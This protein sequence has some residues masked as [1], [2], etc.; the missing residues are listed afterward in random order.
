MNGMPLENTYSK[1]ISQL[2]GI[3]WAPQYIVNQIRTN[4]VYVANFPGVNTAR[5]QLDAKRINYT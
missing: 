3:D 2:T 5:N 1:Q 4:G